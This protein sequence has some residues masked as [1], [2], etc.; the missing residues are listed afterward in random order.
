[1][2]ST[3]LTASPEEVC[4]LGHGDKVSN[5]GFSCG[6]C[7]PVHLELPLL[8]NQL[9]LLFSKHLLQHTDPDETEQHDGF[10]DCEYILACPTWR[11]LVMRLNFSSGL[12]WSAMT[13]GPSD[14]KDSESGVSFKS[15]FHINT[16]DCIPLGLMLISV[17][18]REEAALTCCQMTTEP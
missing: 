13:Q 4:Y 11:F 14:Y 3:H 8:K 16:P 15:S 7:A 1:M 9:Q 5:M 17:S 10:S 18:Q 6:R 2:K 12:S